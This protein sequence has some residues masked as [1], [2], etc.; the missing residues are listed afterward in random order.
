MVCMCVCVCVCVCV[1]M[2][3]HVFVFHAR[4]HVV[5]PSDGPALIVQ[6]PYGEWFSMWH[7][8]RHDIFIF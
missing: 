7:I 2:F 3:L 6:T 8:N 1:C 4:V 5:S